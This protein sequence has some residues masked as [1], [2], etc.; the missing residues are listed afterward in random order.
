MVNR[1]RF[2]QLQYWLFR[3]LLLILFIIAAFKV[4]KH[5]WPF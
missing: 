4:V 5:E 1:D 3:L 2:E